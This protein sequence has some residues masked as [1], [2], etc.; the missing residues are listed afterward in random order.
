LYPPSKHAPA[1]GIVRLVWV[2]SSSTMQGLARIRPMLEAVGRAVPGVRLR[3]IC[4]RFL[5]FGELPVEEC[6]WNPATEGIALGGADIG[7]SWTPDDEWS[8]GKCGLKVLQYMAAGLPVIANPVGVLAT[9]VQDGVTGL[10]ARTEEQW[11]AAVQ[12]LTRDPALRRR[13]GAAGRA[14][15]ESDF[16]VSAGGRLW[17]EL[18]DGMARTGRVAG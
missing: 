9:M 17:R 16:S 14:R 6:A 5:Q 4:D 2:G 13:M 1:D 15:V 10:H 18:L 7:L 11:I 12:K 3:M 8:R